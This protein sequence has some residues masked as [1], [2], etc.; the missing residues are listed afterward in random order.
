MKPEKPTSARILHISDLHIRT[1]EDAGTWCGQLVDDLKIELDCHRLDA[2]ILSGD[3]A[4]KSLPGEY[5]A[6]AQF[7]NRICEDFR[8]APSGVV[9]VPGNH[10]LNWDLS[11]KGY[12][13][14]YRKDHKGKLK[15]GCFIESGED[16]IQ[17]R[18]EVEYKQRFSHF[19]NF[20]QAVKGEPY[21]LDYESQGTLHHFPEHN[22]LI[23]GLNSAWNLD[24]HFKDR[25]G[26]HPGAVNDALIRINKTEAYMD[27]LKFAVWH[28]PLNSPFED[29]IKDAGFMQRL[30]QSGFRVVLHG[31]IH[32]ADSG[33]YRYGVTE[34]GRRIHIVGAG[35]FGAPVKK[36]TPGHPLQYNLLKLDGSQLTVETRR[37]VEINGAWRPDAIWLRGQGKDPAPRYAIHLSDAPEAGDKIEHDAGKIKPDAAVEFDLRLE[38]EIEAYRERAG[39]LHE[40]LALAGFRTRIRA[41]ILV[42]DIYVPLRAMID[43]RGKGGACFA[44]AEDAESRLRESEGAEEISVPEAFLQSEKLKRC[45]IVILGDPGSGKTTHLKRLLLWLLRGETGKIGLPE[46][47]IPIF[48]PLRELKDINSGLD[49]FIQEQLDQPHMGLAKGFGERLLKRGNLLFLLDGLDEV[50]DLSHRDKVARWIEA[51]ARIHRSCR[52]AITCRFA[53]YSPEVRLNEDFLEMHMRPLTN[54]QA[55]DFIHNWY[56]IVE[57]GLSTNHDQA[58]IVAAEKADKLLARLDEREFR[59]RRVFELTRNPLLLTNLCLVHWDRGN[60]PKNRSRLYEECIEVLLDLWHGAI[61]LKSRTTARNGMR[62]LQ[63]AALWM[64]QEEGRTRAKASELSPAMEPALKAVQWPH[65]SA[66]EFLKAVRDESGLLTGWDQEHYGFMH[67]GFQEY[68]AAREIRSRAF[69]DPRVLREL[70]GH[71]GESWWEEVSLLM[72]A[73]E[74][75]SL[76]TPYMREVVKRGAFVEHSNLVELCLDDAAETSSRPFIELLEREP[77]KDQELWERQFT[78]FQILSRMDPNVIENLIPRLRRHPSPNIRRLTGERGSRTTRDRFISKKSGYELVRIP[79]GV[80]M[81]GSPEDEEGRRDSEGP[82]HEV[83]VPEFYIGRYPVTNEDY[84]RFLDANP[85]AREPKYWSDRKYNQPRQPV[86][87]MSWEDAKKYAVWSGLCLPSEAQW[88]Y[89]CRAGSETRYYTGDS[90]AD[91]ARAGWYGKNSGSRLHPVGEKEANAFGLHDMHGNV[92]EWLEDYFHK[93][94]E[95]APADGSA[96]VDDPRG[97]SRVHRGG[98]WISPA[99][100]CRTANRGRFYHRIGNPDFGF[101]LAGPSGQ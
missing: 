54:D 69:E 64:H 15:E 16:I 90:E 10:D 44:D 2:L 97:S 25:A 79:G 99:W 30:A 101:R 39:A 61:G 31:H 52:F 19:S 5:A 100:A 1:I 75:P 63:P 7:L 34:D 37:R 33:L 77:G 47:I 55:R 71:F 29:R 87:G 12:K 35:T 28:H 72:L 59:A 40:K 57:T 53:G 65:G 78:A 9:L 43:L 3:I 49:A 21:P 8:L 91:L 18:D 81:M 73:L 94:Y 82:L 46:D 67:L 66:A 92:D 74:D 50:A 88:E 45:G 83:H 4:D 32:K 96:W 95:D 48:L 24:Y 11:M 26:V 6:A 36:W 17:V 89:A 22:L 86:V 58:T 51:G 42:E 76:F 23:L 85:N 27:C 68:L 60:L 62:V 13:L 14:K 84:D 93:D 70:A 80:F 38:G 98:G 56:K 20:Y 41:P